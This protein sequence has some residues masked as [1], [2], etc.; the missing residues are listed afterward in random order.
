MKHVGSR[1]IKQAI[2]ENPTGNPALL[3]EDLVTCNADFMQED[4]DKIL[5]IVGETECSDSLKKA[6][7]S[8]QTQIVNYRNTAVEEFFK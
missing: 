7:E 3:A 8:L 6:A 1:S 5:T 4:L 2:E